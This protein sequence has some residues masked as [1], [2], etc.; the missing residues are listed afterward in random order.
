MLP[1]ITNICNFAIFYRR[2]LQ[3]N[4]LLLT[5]V[6]TRRAVRGIV[7]ETIRK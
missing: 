2:E 1:S 7:N 5:V 6:E 4:K 3:F